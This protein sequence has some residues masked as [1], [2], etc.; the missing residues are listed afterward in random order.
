MFLADNFVGWG[1]SG[2]LDKA[3]ATKEYTGADCA[4]KSDA[5]SDEQMRSLGQSGPGQDVM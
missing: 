1:P 3:S 2:R 5:L 4:I